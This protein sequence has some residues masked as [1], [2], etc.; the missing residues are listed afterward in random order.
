MCLW[1]QVAA[2]EVAT[3][4]EQ[5][6]GHLPVTD[7]LCLC[8]KNGSPFL[9]SLLRS[10]PGGAL[11]KPCSFET[12]GPLGVHGVKWV[13]P[14]SASEVFFRPISEKGSSTQEGRC[15]RTGRWGEEETF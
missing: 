6:V 13:N 1:N 2:L 15:S 14:S 11:S 8:E 12:W 10:I 7:F 5:C 9:G 4:G 3:M